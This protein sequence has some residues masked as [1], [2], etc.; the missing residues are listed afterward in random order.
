MTA[1]VLAT[2]GLPFPGAGGGTPPTVVRAVPLPLRSLLPVGPGLSLAPDGRL[3][4]ATRSRS[5]AVR[6]CAPMWATAL[7]VVWEQDRG[8]TVRVG[9]RLGE[10]RATL[11]AEGGPDPGTAEF[12]P[13]AQGTNLLWTGGGRCAVVRLSLPP[14]TVLAH[15]RV[16]FINP[17]GTAAGPGTAPPDPTAGLP[18]A[19]AATR[20]PALVTREEWGADPRLLNCTPDVADELRMGF[21]HHTAGRNDYSRAEADDVVR[22][23]YAYHTNGRGWCDIGYNFL[24]DRFGRIYEGRSGGPTLPVVGAAQQ[25]FNTGS[26]SVSLIGNFETRAP[27]RAAMRALRRLLAWRLD[28]AHLPPK[29]RTWMTSGGGDNNR[30]AAGTVVRLPVIAG[31]R[32]TG[33]TACPGDA[34]YRRL[35]GLRDAVARTGLP[36]I[37]R[38]RLST[39]RLTPD[40]T[41]L[42][43][44]AGASGPLTWSVAA[45]DRSG[46]RVATFPPATGERLALTWDGTGDPLPRTP[47]RYEVR[48][49]ARNG[50]GERA[51]PAILPFRVPR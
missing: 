47:G 17:S 41:R 6:A 51:R 7:G 14:G 13:G 36:K 19:S 32:D 45:F 24:I 33:L 42:R 28:V 38:P 2:G 37:Y 50:D 30:F 22:A 8:G 39:T 49:R 29:G 21:V 31:H 16:V 34:V 40:V 4:A 10:G 44:R 23:I 11:P 25:G 35:P 20:D 3:V 1:L 48:I 27:P 46:A 9:V 18:P 43:I 5:R 12:R 15:P 26:F